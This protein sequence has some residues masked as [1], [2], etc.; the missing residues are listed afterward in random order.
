MSLLIV[1]ML[2]LPAVLLV[3]GLGV[4]LFVQLPI[5]GEDADSFGVISF[6]LALLSGYCTF[7]NTGP[8]EVLSASFLV[9][10]SLI[11]GA[12]ASALTCSAARDNNRRA[13]RM[14]HHRWCRILSVVWLERK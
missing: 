13:E 14:R 4:G 2:S 10:F 5:S 7:H 6:W 1:I 8:A 3:V 12:C 11:F 9:V